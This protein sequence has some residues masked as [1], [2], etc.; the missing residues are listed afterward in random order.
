MFRP[1]ESQY[2]ELTDL[3]CRHSPRRQP[4]P[5]FELTN[6]VTTSESM[7]VLTA[8]TGAKK[9]PPGEEGGGV[10]RDWSERSRERVWSFLTSQILI[11]SSPDRPRDEEST[12]FRDRLLLAVRRKCGR[13][14]F[15]LMQPIFWSE[16]PY[17]MVLCLSSRRSRCQTPPR[18]SE[19]HIS[20]PVGVRSM[21][22]IRVSSIEKISLETPDV[23]D[24]LRIV[25]S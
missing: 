10:G 6:S 3:S 13:V 8:A 11:R 7:S 17:R 21:L 12:H 4:F 1:L 9:G 25:Q 14:G 22:E 2:A 20:C 23:N 18:A 5:R 16:R 24:R 15:T 19:I